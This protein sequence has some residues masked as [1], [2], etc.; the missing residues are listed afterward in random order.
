MH[1]PAYFAYLFLV[2]TR[3]PVEQVEQAGPVEQAEPRERVGRAVMRVLRVMTDLEARATPVT[4]LLRT[5]LRAVIRA[6]VMVEEAK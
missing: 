4:N 6:V 2:V 3:A 5:Q 1:L